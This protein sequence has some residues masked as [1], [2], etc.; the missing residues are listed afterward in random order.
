MTLKGEA[1]TNY[2][3]DYMRRRR[4]A[5]RAAAAGNP[6]HEEPKEYAGLPLQQRWQHS[7]ANLCGD[8]ISPAPYWRKH[9]PG[10]EKFNCPSDVKTL[11]AEAVTELAA[12]A[13]TVGVEQTA[14]ARIREPGAA[15]AKAATD[16]ALARL[17]KANKELRAKLSALTAWHEE[18]MRKH[19]KMPQRTY[20]AVI[21][22]LHPDQRQHLT[23]KQIDEACG[24]FT[25]WK[26]GIK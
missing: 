26:R 23:A 7:L 16:D 11:V 17:K 21:K 25:Q 18:E 20:A 13:A 9:F 4:A 1:R 2:M 15:Q 12:I 8:I 5:A 22:C 6:A 10:W 3:R 19:G 14:R 24:L